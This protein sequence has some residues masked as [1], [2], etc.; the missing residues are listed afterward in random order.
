MATIGATPGGGVQRLTLTDEDKQARDLFVKWL[1]EL[2]LDITIDE[3]GNIF[4]RRA[5]K[6]N[7]LPPVMSGSH[8]DSQPKGGRFDGILGVMGPLEVLRT[9]HEN[10]IQ[11]ERPIVIVDWTNEEG[12]RFAPAMVS[13][14]VWAGALERDYAYGRTDINGL[15]FLNELE[16]IGY[17]GKAPAR[18]W[19]VHAY[20]EYHIEQGPMLEREG[21][22][23]GAPKGILCLHWYDIYLEGEAN[24]VGPTP[25]EGRH[26]ALCA[27][28]EMILKVNQLPDKMGGN[29]V[30]TVGEIQNH[31]NSRNIIPDKVHFTVDIR[32]WDDDHAIRAWEDLKADFET[33]ARRRG[34]PIRIEE[35]WRVEHS[36]FDEKL[37][38]RVLETAGDLGYSSL[39]MVSGAGHD[40]SY[41]NQIAPTAMIFV[42]SIGGRS[43]VEVE[44]T[45]WQDCEAGGNVLLHCLIRA[46]NEK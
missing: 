14:G 46:A 10:D 25:M 20:Y 21:L 28:A 44:E 11:T 13:S 6:N 1:E 41:M 29:M 15:T 9:L 45:T 26:D 32:S 43:H 23:I 18:K 42:P 40:A 38:Q 3:M 30:A 7:D 17:R 2:E 27:A 8:I 39:H 34:C 4:G 35:T 5:G 12:S 19:P 16:R 33:I 31:P 36:P 37:V 22:Q 24:Q